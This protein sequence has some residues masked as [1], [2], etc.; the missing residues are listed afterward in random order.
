MIK[1]RNSIT[2]PNSADRIIYYWEREGGARFYDGV[3]LPSDNFFTKAQLLMAIEASNHIGARIPYYDE[4]LLVKPL[5]NKMTDINTWLSRIPAD[6]VITDDSEHISW[7]AISRLFQLFDMKYMSLARKT[8]ILHKK[9]PNL[10]PILDS[11]LELDY[12]Y[13][14]IGDC[15]GVSGSDWAI[16]CIV[17]LKK[18]IDTNKDE[19]TELQRTLSIKYEYTYDVSL[20][21]LLDIL[22]WSHFF[23][24]EQT[25]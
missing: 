24:K 10:I 13:P 8:K 11:V 17:E 16:K 9:R 3:R 19:L 12:C 20:L 6:T 15:K 22:I 14:I 23:Y 7:D 5:I 18:D 2:I 21:R 4:T 25:S 1:L